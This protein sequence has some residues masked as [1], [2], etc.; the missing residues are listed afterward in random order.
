MEAVN[1]LKSTLKWF[2][3]RPTERISTISRNSFHKF[4]HEERSVFFFLIIIR[5]IFSYVHLFSFTHV[6][7]RILPDGG[8]SGSSSS[9]S[10]PEVSCR[11]LWPVNCSRALKSIDL[12]RN[13]SVAVPTLSN[14]FQKFPFFCSSEPVVRTRPRSASILF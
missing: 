9:S 8:G 1:V 2:A 5:P 3:R 13:R 12:T 4:S 10:V 7:R 14:A 6:P 11:T